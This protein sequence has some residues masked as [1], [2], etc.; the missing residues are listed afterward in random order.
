MIKSLAP[1]FEPLL[2]GGEA[3][4]IR[5][6]G[7][8]TFR[9]AL[10]SCNKL[11]YQEWIVLL[12]DAAH[13][14]LPPTGEGVNSGLEDSEI[15]VSCITNNNDSNNDNNN[16]Y[17]TNGPFETFNQKRHPDVQALHQYASK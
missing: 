9:G 4:L 12:G 1:L 10:V 5:F 14:V 6:F 16:D 11:H 7:R 17:V 2:A 15:L 3:E 8:R 13:S